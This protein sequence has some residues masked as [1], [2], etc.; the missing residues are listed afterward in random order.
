MRGR[1][2]VVIVD[3]INV[4][5]LGWRQIVTISLTC[6]GMKVCADAILYRKIDGAIWL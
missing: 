1:G 4:H 6:H 2:I 5:S 3:P